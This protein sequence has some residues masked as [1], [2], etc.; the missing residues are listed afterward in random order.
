MEAFSLI[1]LRSMMSTSR[2]LKNYKTKTL[3][4][5]LAKKILQQY[6]ERPQPIVYYYVKEGINGII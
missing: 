3:T 1:Q 2:V 6:Q 4:Y 5:K